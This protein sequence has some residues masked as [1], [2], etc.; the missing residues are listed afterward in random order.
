M[1]FIIK[2][3]LIIYKYKQSVLDK[4]NIGYKINQ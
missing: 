3:K 4:K 1:W 2:N